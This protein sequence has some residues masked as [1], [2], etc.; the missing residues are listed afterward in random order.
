[1]E[2]FLNL[3]CKDNLDADLDA[4]RLAQITRPFTS[5][6]NWISFNP[7]SPPT[8]LAGT[9]CP[10]CFVNTSHSKSDEK[11]NGIILSLRWAFLFNLLTFYSNKSP[12]KVGVF[13]QNAGFRPDHNVTLINHVASNHR[14]YDKE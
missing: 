13:L 3:P 11:P 4:D 9:L 1:M 7:F 10:K 12:R 2:V 6:L 14:P 8:W 5:T